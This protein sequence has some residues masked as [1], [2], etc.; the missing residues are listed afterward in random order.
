MNELNYF[1]CFVTVGKPRI[2]QRGGIYT[3]DEIEAELR[4]FHIS[5]ALILHRFSYENHPT[6]GN[7]EVL[8]ITSLAGQAGKDN[9]HP[10]WVLLPEHTRE[11]PS[12]ESRAAR[13]FDGPPPEELTSQ[14]LARGV[15]VARVYPK[16]HHWS[17]AEWSA[18]GLLRAL[19][20]HR[21]PLSIQLDETDWEEIQALAE[22]HPD[23]PI[24][25]TGALY[26]ISRLIFPLF[27]RHP[28]LYL[29]IAGYQVHRGLEEATEVVGAR[30]FLF[31]SRLPEFTPGAAIM[32]INYARISDEDRRLIAGDNLRR[33]LSEVRT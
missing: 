31:G 1:D 29:E 24:I 11:M 12:V 2:G 6:V 26:R 10:V 16:T 25:V 32:M 21:F 19:E 27:K 5:E 28:N 8:K 9:L 15:K 17:L 20:A 30:Q 23:L 4:Y 18:G 7:E 13:P 3:I 14:M 33:I 22:R